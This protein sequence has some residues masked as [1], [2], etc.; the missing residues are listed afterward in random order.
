MVK[1]V[2][3]VRKWGVPFVG[4]QIQLLW[5]AAFDF[6]GK[7]L[8][9]NS[10]NNTNKKLSVN[11]LQ[12]NC[13]LNTYW[14][15]MLSFLVLRWKVIT[16]LINCQL[17]KIIGVPIFQLHFSFDL[18]IKLDGSVGWFRLRKKPLDLCKPKFP[19]LFMSR[20]LVRTISTAYY[21]FAAC[22]IGWNNFEQ[23][24]VLLVLGIGMKCFGG[25]SWLQYF[26]SFG[27]KGWNNIFEPLTYPNPVPEPRLDTA[28][29]RSTNILARPTQSS[30]HPDNK[31]PRAHWYKES[32][33]GSSVWITVSGRP[34]LHAGGTQKRRK[35]EIWLAKT[36]DVAYPNKTKKTL[37]CHQEPVL[38]MQIYELNCFPKQTEM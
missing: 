21:L 3:W 24:V 9:T 36:S 28:E 20:R 35:A 32:H 11:L 19:N 27:M 22:S 33:L 29:L 31:W 2:C 8:V 14:L 12:I 15:R 4:G 34:K 16:K 25:I 18:L 23:G 26:G 10:E 37:G 6:L 38:L 7:V 5:K 13:Q 17:W 1:K 30:P